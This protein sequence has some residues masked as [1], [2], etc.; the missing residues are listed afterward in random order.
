MK[1][2]MCVLESASMVKESGKE[3]VYTVDVK[4]EGEKRGAHRGSKESG[5]VNEGQQSH[6]LPGKSLS[7]HVHLELLRV[8][9][10][11]G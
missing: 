10:L 2:V 9:I 8:E 5:L 1:V 4:G 11:D 7:I 6:T 3:R